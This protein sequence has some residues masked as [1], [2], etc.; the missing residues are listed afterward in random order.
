MNKSY[1]LHIF[2]I[3]TVIA[4][5]LFLFYEANRYSRIESGYSNLLSEMRLL[6]QLN[7]ELNENILLSRTMI[8]K[9]YDPIVRTSAQ[10]N[11]V[12]ASVE[13]GIKDVLTIPLSDI[14]LSP[15]DSRAYEEAGENLKTSFGFYKNLQLKRA[16]Q[17]EVFKAG[18]AILKNSVQYLPLL[19]DEVIK[20]LPAKDKH[21]ESNIILIN[22]L[23]H[24]VLLF[25]LNNPGQSQEKIAQSIDKLNT[26]MKHLSKE[27]QDVIAS[28]LK[29]VAILAEKFTS[30]SNVLRDLIVQENGKAL[31]KIYQ[32]ADT[33]NGLLQKEREVFNTILLAVAGLLVVYVMGVLVMLYRTVR[34]IATTNKM[35]EK[36]NEAKSEFLA[37]M[38]HEIRTPMNGIIG[39]TQLLEETE[40]DPDQSQSVRAI[41]RSGESLLL[42]LNDIL[43][44]SKIEA[45]E[46]TLEEL[47]FNL[48]GGMKHV[49]DL[50]SQIASR[51]GIVLDYKYD[52]RIPSSVIG[53]PTRIGQVVTN[54]VGNALKFTEAGTVSLKVSADPDI[55]DGKIVFIFNIEDTGVGIPEEVQQSLFKKFSQGDTS[56]SRKFGGTGLGLAISKNLIEIMGGTI[57]FS[58]K[59][60][61]G[62]I[63]TARIPLKK[64]N[65][66]WFGTKRYDQA[67]R[68]LK[69][70]S[71]FQSKKYWSSMTIPSICSS[72]VNC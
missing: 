43:D 53:D 20:A 61:Q 28:Y 72:H 39:L 14:L 36:A 52:D 5:M 46:F 54:L 65:P 33:R 31:E 23:Y 48:N 51:K 64:S 45:G 18:N 67:F 12:T 35:L 10:M 11:T 57:T 38:S 58:S 56:T 47:P 13:A 34:R 66:K 44:F 70:A 40:L 41:L 25:N 55:H 19:H 24:Q 6:K 4:T 62:T 50:M 22:S 32:Y 49:V 71:N 2:F 21:A 59:V 1:R 63:F 8:L 69:P 7:S 15:K 60:G 3:A 68:N 29:H 42:L 30:V 37:N 27:S 16:E 17:M 26:E 9:D